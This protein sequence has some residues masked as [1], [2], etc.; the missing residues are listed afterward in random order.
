MEKNECLKVDIWEEVAY[1]VYNIIYIYII[2]YIN[3][4]FQ[5]RYV[6]QLL[7]G[8]NNLCCWHC[9]FKLPYYIDGDV[10]LSQSN[11]IM[12]YLAR[13]HGLGKYLLNLQV[14]IL[15]IAS[16]ATRKNGVCNV[17]VFDGLIILC[18]P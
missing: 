18:L 3:I 10:K 11:T 8:C 2:L 7:N 12:R 1:Y 16:C 17:F 6:S 4:K 14:H 5:S 15:V 9:S 13:K